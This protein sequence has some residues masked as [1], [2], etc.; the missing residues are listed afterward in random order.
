MLFIFTE[1]KLN[2][3]KYL[4]VANDTDKAIQKFYN[5]YFGR[6]DPLP[7]MNKHVLHL[8]IDG[9]KFFIEKYNCNILEDVIEIG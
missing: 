2:G 5:F 4:T 7:A 3:Y 6:C 1:D 8:T 9:R